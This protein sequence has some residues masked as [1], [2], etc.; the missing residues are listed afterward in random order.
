MALVVGLCWENKHISSLRQSIKINLKAEHCLQTRILHNKGLLCQ[1]DS[2]RTD[3]QCFIKQ[4]IYFLLFR[5]NDM[6]VQIL[7]RILQNFAL[8]QSKMKSRLSELQFC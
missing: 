4:H 8:K 2:V 6:Y 5:R 7:S 3:M 1:L